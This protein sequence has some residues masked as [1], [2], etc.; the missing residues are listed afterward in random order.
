MTSPSRNLLSNNGFDT[1]FIVGSVLLLLVLGALQPSHIEPSPKAF[2][3][4]PVH[5][6]METFSVVVCAA[7]FAVGWSTYDTER[8]RYIIVLAC[9]LL[10]VGLID[11]AHFLSYP[12]MPKF[13][14]VSASQKSIFFW[15]VA[16]I[17]IAGALLYTA[18]SHWRPFRNP[19]N[20]YA[21]LLSGMVL[22]VIAYWIGLYHLDKTPA[23]YIGAKGLTSTKIV[24]EFF[25]AGAYA[26]AGFVLARRYVNESQEWMR[27]LVLC[28]MTM[29]VSELYFTLFRV[30]WDVLILLGHAYKVVAYCLLYRAVFIH[31]VRFPMEQLEASESAL[32]HS[33]SA[34][35]RT[36]IAVDHSPDCIFMFDRNNRFVYVNARAI[37]RF[38]YSEREFLAMGAEDISEGFTE[39]ARAAFWQ[40]LSAGNVM[41]VETRCRTR[42]NEWFPVEASTVLID[43]GSQ[44]LGCTVLRD[45]SERLQAEQ[46]V[47]TSLLNE[48]RARVEAQTKS[49]FLAQMSHE[50]RTPMNGILGMSELLLSS[51]LN[52]TQGNY[53]RIIHS[54]ATSL[55]T[56]I[57][58]ILDISKIEA[59][60][61]RIEAV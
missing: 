48:E 50:I 45:T 28:C 39:D 52:E 57:N 22:V 49:A 47:R 2:F 23:L 32:R 25:L 24:L 12:G 11:T 18:F 38:G 19:K 37:E 16:R 40:G 10:C 36:Q 35:R 21:L 51:G 27:D 13:V 44:Q 6:V 17:V 14:T 61:L 9:A 20:R 41:R 53:C 7:I 58:D 5:T 26:L 54:S 33:Q 31:N 30:P 46:Q 56:V 1:L 29:T 43:E 55:L 42:N 3:P 59:G 34:L 4:V 8:P 60:R 15:L